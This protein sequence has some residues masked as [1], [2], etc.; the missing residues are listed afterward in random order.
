MTVYL[1]LPEMA[2]FHK[3]VHDAIHA[4]REKQGRPVTRKFFQQQQ[5]ASK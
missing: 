5:V 2:I 4:V 1:P 3:I